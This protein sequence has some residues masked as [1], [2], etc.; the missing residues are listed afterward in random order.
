MAVERGRKKYTAL[1]ARIMTNRACR[2]PTPVGIVSL[3]KPPRPPRPASL[4]ES[5][6]R[7]PADRRRRVW[8]SVFYGNLNPRRRASRREHEV[9]FHSV[10]WHSSHLLAVAMGILL[11]SVADAF[12]TVTLLSGGAIEVN[13]VMAAVIYKS[14]ALFADLKMAM[15]GLGVMLMV[16]LARYRFMRVVRVELALYAILLGY[17]GLLG[18]EFYLLRDAVDIPGL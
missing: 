5:E 2:R 8:W 6:R 12:M 1:P 9:G 11:L 15:T 7:G 16:Y 17:A 18:Y 10:D 3:M 13:P 4:Y 14:A